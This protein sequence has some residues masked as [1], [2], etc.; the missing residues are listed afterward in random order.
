[1][2]SPPNVGGG[3]GRYLPS[4]VMVASGEPGMPVVC[5]AFA[6]RQGKASV[7][8]PMA[9]ANTFTTFPPD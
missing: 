9:K 2:I 8:A 1:L 5:C 7:S 4:I 3:D 6:G